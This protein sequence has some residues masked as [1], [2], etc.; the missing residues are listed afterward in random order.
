VDI[1]L[2]DAQTL[3]V[4]E[5]RFCC[6]IGK[7]GLIDAADKREGDN[8]TPRGTYPLRACYWR[9]DKLDPPKT[10]LPLV[11]LRPN[12]GWCDDPEHVRYNQLVSI[13]SPPSAALNIS[14]THAGR[15]EGVQPKPN[16]SSYETLWRDDDCYD[17]I[18]SIGY[19]D[20]PI[21]A[22]RGSAIFMHIAKPDYSGTE[23]CVAL[24]KEDLLEVLA[25]LSNQACIQMEV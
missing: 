19:N 4:D 10:A 2:L 16:F 5:A 9:P 21:L 7:G 13:P 6:A 25:M 18:L 1:I 24:A 12:M 20:D 22:G 14:P 15:V 8:M 11:P 3:A 17:L 23:G